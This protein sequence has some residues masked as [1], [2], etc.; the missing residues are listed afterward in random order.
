M[1]EFSLLFPDHELGH[2]HGRTLQTEVKS[3]VMR[4]QDRGKKISIKPKPIV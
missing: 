4:V 2:D 1:C 3:A